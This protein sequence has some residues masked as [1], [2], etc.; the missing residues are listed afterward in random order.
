MMKIKIKNKI[1]LLIILFANLSYA[2][3]LGIGQVG[4]RYIYKVNGIVVSVTDGDTIDGC[5]VS[6]GSG[7]QCSDSLNNIKHDKL[8]IALKNVVKRANMIEKLKAENIQ[9]K[10]ELAVVSLFK[11]KSNQLKNKIVDLEQEIIDVKNYAVKRVNDKNIKLSRLSSIL[12]K[13]NAQ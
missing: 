11:A 3:I 9:L 7:L 10:E 5:I 4:D 1:L 12:N 2:D 8:Q 6:Y 13:I